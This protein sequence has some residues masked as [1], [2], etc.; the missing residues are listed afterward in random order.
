[1]QTL[2]SVGKN[3]PGEEAAVISKEL[4][5]ILAC[6][7]NKSP[8]HL[9]EPQLLESLNERIRSGEL[10]TREGEI[11]VD[12]LEE[13]LIREDGKVLYPVRE[14]IPIMMISESISLEEAAGDPS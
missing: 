3:F 1:V 4:L 8:L 12:L 11:V 9:A 13:G 10:L 14:G 6:P 2:P 7:E 5:E